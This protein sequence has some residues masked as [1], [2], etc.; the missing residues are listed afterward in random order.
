MQA[1]Q[2]IQQ[3]LTPDSFFL[4]LA[5]IDCGRSSHWIWICRYHIIDTDYA[6]TNELSDHVPR[7]LLHA[8]AINKT[9]IPN[10][11]AEYN[12]NFGLIDNEP[13]IES[14]ARLCEKTCLEM[15]DQ[16]TQQ[17]EEYK[18]G[19]V[20]DGG[21][22]YPIWKIRNEKFLKQVQNIFITD[23]DDG[24]PL[25]QLPTSW[26]KYFRD[27]TETSPIRHLTA[28]RYDPK[29]AKWIRPDDHIDDLYYAAL[30]CEAAFFI[31]VEKQIR[32]KNFI[33]AFSE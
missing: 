6:T 3:K 22:T 24:Y 31:A 33:K 27:N 21:E 13:D 10:T 19:E 9:A 12:V 2:S 15:A 23:Y 18:E 8:G 17:F 28:P 11:L 14:S 25:I 26:E 1:T 7:E 30:F 5:G 4:T 16:K 29:D 32:M 20:I